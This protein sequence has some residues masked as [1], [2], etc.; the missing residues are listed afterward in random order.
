MLV[1]AEDLPLA[2]LG[3]QSAGE[4]T[5][6]GGDDGLACSA[7]P[8]G[9]LEGRGIDPPHALHQGI[10]TLPFHCGKVGRPEER[11]SGN[12]GGDSSASIVEGNE[13]M[14]PVGLA[15][16]RR[17]EA[18]DHPDAETMEEGPGSVETSGRIMVAAHG[19]DLDMGITAT[20]LGEKAVPEGLGLGRGVGG[21][22]DVAA[23]KAGIGF[24]LAHQVEKPGE[25]GRLLELPGHA[26][27]GMPQVPVRGVQDLHGAPSYSKAKDDLILASSNP[28]GNPSGVILANYMERESTI[29]L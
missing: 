25:K 29:D 9:F 20:C 7:A 3:D 28:D 4:V 21:I 19:N 16:R 6:T 18:S 11:D 17:R 23:D 22:E 12:Q 15:R 27:E 10:Q 8:A 2:Q 5:V 24:L 1:A 13:E 14:V 26:V